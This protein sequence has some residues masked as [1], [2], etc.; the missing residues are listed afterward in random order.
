[1]KTQ[2]L[3]RNNLVALP[4]SSG[5]ASI[6]ILGT[7][8]SNLLHYGYI[9]SKDAYA[10]LTKT[11][12]IALKAWWAELEPVLKKLTGDDK[13]MGRFVVYKNFP[14]EVLEMSQA[15]Y[16]VNQ[17]LMYW[18]LPNELF[19][20][21][22][23]PRDKMLEKRKLKVLQAADARSL[24]GIFD[25]LLRS[26]ARWT[27]EQKD[28][29]LYLVK[30]ESFKWD[31]A[32]IA[33]KENMALFV[34]GLKDAGIEIQLSSATD[35]LRLA[36]GLSEG[37]VS[38]RT[39]TKFK[40]FTRSERRFLISLL[41][42][43]SNLAEDMARDVERWKRFIAFLHPSDY[44]RYARVNKAAKALYADKVESFN[45]K[46]ENAIKEDD[47]EVLKTLAKRPG[48]FM[49]RFHHLYS[50]FGGDAVKAFARTLPDLTTLQLLKVDRY[51]NTINERTH[52]TIAPRGNW[53]KLQVLANEQPKIKS[54]HREILNEGIRKLLSARTKTKVGT[55]N[56]QDSAAQVK[57]QTNDA[58]LSPFGRGTVFTIPQNIKFVRSASYWRIKSGGYVWFDNGWNF[59]DENWKAK[60]TL[61]WSSTDMGGAAVFSGD[62]TNTKDSEGRACQMIDLYLDKLAA[63]GIRYGVWN[64]LCFSGIKFKDAEVFASLQWGEEA[65]KGKLFEASRAQFTAPVQGDSLTK[66]IL[67]LDVQERKVVYMDANLRSSTSSAASNTKTLEELMPAFV[68]YLDTLP[69][70]YDLFKY[71]R[72]SKN[73]TVITYDDVGL[74]V[75]DVGYVFKPSNTTNKFRQLD[76]N[77]VLA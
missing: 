69:S 25:S 31:V 73:G 3:V 60:D 4:D 67:Y 77:Q 30:S 17:I 36:I 5:R 8:T 1:M 49:R 61:C 46:V 11:S 20:A 16:W 70:V 62:P 15:Q 21:D 58:D 35:V 34:S 44:P 10:K 9:L 64:I 50:K 18:G 42:K 51:I 24:K 47:K 40:R 57:L 2:I 45:A 33:F 12:D 59:F 29:A 27:T 38:M 71:T 28:S 56:L 43:T 6:E 23:Q 63:R 74:A 72:R 41:E 19:T 53:T 7:L 22:E 52:R 48:E 14:K 26:P 66:Y 32:N 68:E 39:N 54:G 75:D 65:Q 55:V 13:D 37:D 76:L